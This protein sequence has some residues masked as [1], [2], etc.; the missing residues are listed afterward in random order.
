MKLGVFWLWEVLENI[1][2]MYVRN[3]LL[4]QFLTAQDSKTYI[5]SQRLNLYISQEYVQLN[6]I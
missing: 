5:L 2:E 1:A 4:K 3:L 6:I